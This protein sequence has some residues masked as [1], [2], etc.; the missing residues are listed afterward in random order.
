MFILDNSIILED[1]GLIT[2]IEIDLINTDVF[3]I[4]SECLN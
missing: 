1:T 4:N 2:Y 3:I